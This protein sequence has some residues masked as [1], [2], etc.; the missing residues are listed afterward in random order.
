M[1][2]RTTTL[3]A[4]RTH[5]TSWRGTLPILAASVLWGSTGTTASFAPE[6]APAAAIGSAGLALGGLLLYL[7]GRGNPLRPSGSERLLLVL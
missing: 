6:G 4:A 1:S 5:A 3:D 2:N 7:T